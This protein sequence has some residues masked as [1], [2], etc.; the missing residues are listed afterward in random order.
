ML[1]LSSVGGMAMC[2]MVDRRV[3]DV[4]F[5]YQFGWW[6]FLH[7]PPYCGALVKNGSQTDRHPSAMGMACTQRILELKSWRAGAERLFRRHYGGPTR[8]P[9]WDGVL[10]E[11]VLVD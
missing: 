4:A 8:R 6:C 5:S 3:N 7:A 1:L 10:C 9:R 11:R 2:G